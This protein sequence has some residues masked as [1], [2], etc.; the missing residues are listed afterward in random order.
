MRRWMLISTGAVAIGL[1]VVTYLSLA[2]D[3]PSAPLAV[4][5]VP[6]AA[7]APA[8]NAPSGAP[9]PA[10][11]AAASTGADVPPTGDGSF[12]QLVADLNRKSDAELDQ[13]LAAVD[14]EI[15]DKKLIERANSNSLSLDERRALGDLLRQRDALNVVKTRRILVALDAAGH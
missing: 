14:R 13:G 2:G 8:A 10:L 9:A 4:E 5:T 15:D 1:L 11:P 3:E 12:D 7:A 6:A